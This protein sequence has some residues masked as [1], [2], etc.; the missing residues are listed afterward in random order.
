MGDKTRE[1]RAGLLG[2]YD[3]PVHQFPASGGTVVHILYK[4]IL[5]CQIDK[6]R[7]LNLPLCALPAEFSAF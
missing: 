2:L 7:L 5:V 4:R 3:V 1:L 6:L